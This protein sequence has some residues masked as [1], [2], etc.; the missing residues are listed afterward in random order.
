MSLCLEIQ[1]DQFVPNLSVHREQRVLKQRSLYTSSCFLTGASSLGERTFSIRITDLR[2]KI[3]GWIDGSVV[4]SR[5]L[6]FSIQRPQDSSQPSLNSRVS[7]SFYGLCR[8]PPSM[9]Y[10]YVHP[11]KPTYFWLDCRDPSQRIVGV[12]SFQEFLPNENSPFYD[13][14]PLKRQTL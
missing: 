1:W 7:K 11:G 14:V 13:K 5:G 2:T 10:T 6:G 3:W 12:L 8:H 9:G 4:K